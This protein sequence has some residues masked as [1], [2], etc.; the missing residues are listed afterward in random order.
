MTSLERCNGVISDIAVRNVNKTFFLHNL[1]SN[2]LVRLIWLD[3]IT[4]FRHNT[5][6][7]NTS[8]TLN[9][10][11]VRLVSMISDANFSGETPY[12]L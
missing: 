4:L 3:N 7:I 10:L 2:S 9:D 6:G 11:Q 12:N 1:L 5:D 8:F